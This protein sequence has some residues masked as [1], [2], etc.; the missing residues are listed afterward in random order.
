MPLHADAEVDRRRDT[1]S[2]RCTAAGNTC[3]RDDLA[4]ASVLALQRSIGNAAVSALLQPQ[5]A[6]ARAPARR[7]CPCGGVI[8]DGREECDECRRRR[9]A[10]EPEVARSLAR[11]TVAKRIA[12]PSRRSSGR[13][14]LQRRD[15]C[16]DAGVC[17]SEPDEPLASSVPGPSSSSQPNMCVAQPG[18][19]SAGTMAKAI[20]ASAFMRPD[21]TYAMALTAG[22][23]TSTGYTVPEGLLASEALAGQGIAT[24]EGLVAG[25]ALTV[26]GSTVAQG[27]TLAE[28]L[29]AAGEGL[30]VVEAGGA[31][32]IEAASGPVGW[33]AGAVVLVAA[34]GL[35]LTAYL[36]SDKPSAAG[37]PARGPAAAPGAKPEDLVCAPA[38]SSTAVPATQSEVRKYPGQLCSN[39]RLDELHTAMKAV[40]DAG[41]SCSDTAEREALG[42][43]TRKKYDE[44]IKQ[45]Q[46]WPCAEIL[47]RLAATEA[48]LKAREQ[49]QRECFGNQPEP[50]H[51]RQLESARQAVETCR[52]KA[53][54]RGC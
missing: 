16:D 42:A 37:Q 10:N 8:E 6:V 50:G 49:I 20:P 23:T 12:A 13:Q 25:Q 30:L 11:A 21:A 54:A 45:G 5:S 40:C 29:A 26:G 17:R 14:L 7:R 52:A 3:E 27:A 22:F 31:G 48:C 36:L 41:I 4:I 44:L 19:V 51:D 24:A 47:K 32:E 46:G 2:P 15:V 53:A 33:I 9:L 43:T 38:P 28:S 1:T 39:A 35:L 34:G 18:Q